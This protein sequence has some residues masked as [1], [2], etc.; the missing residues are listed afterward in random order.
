MGQFFGAFTELRDK[1]AA[2]NQNALINTVLKKP[3]Y[4][5][6]IIERI[7]EVQLSTQNVD[8]EGKKL[9]SNRSGYADLTL[10]LAAQGLEGYTRPKK[11][12]N[13]IDLYAT[14]EYHRSHKV[15]ISSIKNDYFEVEADARKGETDLI[16][17]WGP[18]LGLTEESL[19]LLAEF[20]LIEFIPLFL[21]E[22]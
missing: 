4:R 13:N 16:E 20:I 21:K 6:F 10:Q 17:E 22:L 1:I 12:R 2:I 9:S 8:S 5:K 18:V 14:G 19:E 11:G 3:E 15:I 7:T